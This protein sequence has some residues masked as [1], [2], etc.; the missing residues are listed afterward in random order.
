VSGGLL[1][2]LGSYGRFT[3]RLPDDNPYRRPGSAPADAA[4]VPEPMDFSDPDDVRAVRA[5]AEAGR[6]RALGTASPVQRRK[7][8]AI[9]TIRRPEDRVRAWR[10]AET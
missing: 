8:Q 5:L 6:A 7:L 3:G 4:G 2:I 1:M 9:E 10:A